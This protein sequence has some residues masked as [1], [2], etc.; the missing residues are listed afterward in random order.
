MTVR[1]LETSFHQTG[2]VAMNIARK[3]FQRI[4]ESRFAVIVAIIKVF[5]K[6]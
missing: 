1:L 3:H 2:L 4:M 6:Q 5:E